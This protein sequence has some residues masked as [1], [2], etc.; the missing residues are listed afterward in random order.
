V[1]E[2]GT[3]QRLGKE[4]VKAWGENRRGGHGTQR[5][6]SGDKGKTHRHRLLQAL[7]PL[8]KHLSEDL[9]KKTQRSRPLASS[10]DGGGMHVTRKS[11]SS[12]GRG[13]VKRRLPGH[14]REKDPYEPSVE[15]AI[16]GEKGCRATLKKVRHRR[17]KGGVERKRPGKKRG[18]L[19]KLDC[20][21]SDIWPER[22]SQCV[23]SRNLTCHEKGRERKKRDKR[24][25]V[26]RKTRGQGHLA[27]RKK[28]KDIAL[29]EELFR[30]KEIT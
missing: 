19:R 9:V 1:S 8:E 21:R 27:D 4:G 16:V 3:T 14:A 29:G 5:A 24:G 20:C 12:G 2:K 25:A 7:R 17:K 13:E 30:Q 11:S 28:K 23:Q 10:R 18:R 26:Q 22:K 15:G 6:K